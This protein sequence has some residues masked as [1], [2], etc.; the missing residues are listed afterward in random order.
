MTAASVIVPLLVSVAATWLFAWLF[1]RKAGK[2]LRE[3]AAT[4]RHLSV[5]LVN[6]LSNLGLLDIRRA[7]DGTILGLNATVGARERIKLSDA[8]TEQVRKPP[9]L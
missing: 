9:V 6:G 4:I 5:I 8:A 2:E 3:E 1:Y 7:E